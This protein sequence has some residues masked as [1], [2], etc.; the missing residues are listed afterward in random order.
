MKLTIIIGLAGLFCFTNCTR[1]LGTVDIAPVDKVLPDFSLVVDCDTLDSGFDAEVV[2]INN[3][4][5][6]DTFLMI[7]YDQLALL[8]N[9]SLFSNEYRNSIVVGKRRCKTDG[10]RVLNEWGAGY[11]SKRKFLQSPG[12]DNVYLLTLYRVP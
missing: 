9:Y 11:N 8:S 10:K 4:N 2:Q 1:R 6:Q 5:V 7:R 12:T 3:E